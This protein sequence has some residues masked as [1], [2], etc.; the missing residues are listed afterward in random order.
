M[1]KAAAFYSCAGH[2]QQYL[3]SIF[4]S[5]TASPFSLWIIRDI[6]KSVFHYP[7]WLIF[8]I[9]GTEQTDLRNILAAGSS[10][11]PWLPARRAWKK[12]CSPRDNV[13][14][15]TSDSVLAQ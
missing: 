4:S 3:L 2:T 14:A 1:K 7:L 13:K 10:K 5:L 11:Q 9:R 12:L 8:L 6:N 15:T